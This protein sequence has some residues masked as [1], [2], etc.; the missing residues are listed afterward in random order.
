MP[1]ASHARARVRLHFED[2]SQ[3]DAEFYEDLLLRATESI[4]LPL[5][6]DRGRIR[7]HL[8]NS[9]DLGLAAF[10]R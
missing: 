5:G 10:E 4:T 2:I 9:V 6:W 3:Y 1:W 8:R 7:R